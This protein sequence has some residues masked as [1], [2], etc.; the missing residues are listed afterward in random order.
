MKKPGKLIHLASAALLAVGLTPTITAAQEFSD[1]EDNGNLHLRAYGSFFMEGNTRTINSDTAAAG[2]FGG[3][4]IPG[5]LSM[6]DQMYV[7][8]LLPQAQKGKKHVPIVFVHGCCLSSKSWQTTPDGRMGWDEYFARQRFDTY[9]A[10]QVSRARSGFDATAYNKVRTGQLPC[11]PGTAPIVCQELPAILIASDQFAWNIFRWG[12]SPCTTS[13]CSDPANAVPHEDI[14]FPM[15]TVGVGAGSN[16][17]FYNQ[18]IP[19]MNGTL[20]DANP[21]P[22]AAAACTPSA[23]DAAFNTPAQMAA[24][25]SKLG[26]AILVAHS[27]SASFPT[28]AALQPQSGC[29]PWTS[30]DACKV[31]A[32]IQIE[33]GCFGNLTEDQ[34]E[35]LSHIPILIMYGDYSSQPR[36]AATCQTEIDQITAADGDIKYAWLPAL[37][38]DDLYPG[39]PGPIFGNEHMMMLDNN[40]Q[41]IAQILIDWASSRGL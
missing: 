16:L 28:R 8:Y 19:D 11:T 20:S 3:F 5:G 40:N 41:D 1:L 27:E 14:R 21:Q 34:I 2:G 38:P 7:Q 37:V 12:Q 13:P 26:G 35:T 31:K 9:L 24:L 25:A 30:E 29:Y 39:S 23:P 4:P 33:T 6:I 32:I 10:D 36:P 17:Q 22:C 15:N 18:V